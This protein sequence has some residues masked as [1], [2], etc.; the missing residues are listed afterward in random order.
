MVPADGEVDVTGFMGK[1]VIPEV[2]AVVFGW[3]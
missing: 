2:Q 3:A 1:G